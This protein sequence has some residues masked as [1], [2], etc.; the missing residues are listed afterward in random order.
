[1]NRTRRIGLVIAIVMITLLVVACTKGWDGQPEPQ[2]LPATTAA[3]TQGDPIPLP[4]MPTPTPLTLATDAL[5]KLT[6]DEQMAL[7]V[8]PER[9]LRDLAMRLI[10]GVGEIP[11]VVNETT[12]DYEVG[13][14]QL[15]WAHDLERG[16]DF[17]VTAQLI[18]KTDVVYAW[19]EVDQSVDEEKLVATVDRFTTQSYPAERAFFGSEWN[20]GVDNDPRLHILHATGLGSFIA[21]YY[22]SSDEY[23]RVAQPSSNEKEI[24]Y[25]DLNWVNG[26]SQT[27]ST[28]YDNVLAHEFQH[29]IHW[30]TDMNEETWVGEGLSEFAQDVAGFGPTNTFS[31]AFLRVPDTQLTSWG[32][33][34][35]GN[36]PH[37]GAAY[38]FMVYFAQR[39]GAEMTRALV[40]HPAN[41]TDGI[42]DILAWAGSNLTFDDIYADWVVANYVDD[43]NALGSDGLYGYRDFDQEQPQLDATYTDFPTDVQQRT[44][45][46]YGTDYILLKNEGLFTAATDVIFN[47]QGVTTT[48]LADLPSADGP[49]SSWWSNR[50]DTSDTRLTRRFDLSRVTAG[51][52][53]E[54]SATMWWD[55][56]EGYDFAYVIAS[57]DG[58]TWTILEGDS[59]TPSDGLSSFGPGYTGLSEGW[60]SERYDL[61]AFAGEQIYVRFE[62]VTDDAINGR[63]LFI[64]DVTIPAIDYRSNFAQGDGWESEG[65]I[66][67]DNRLRQNWIVQLMTFDGNTLVSVL[68]VKVDDTGHA[69]LP[70]PGLGNGRT[71]VISISGAAPII[72]E[73]ATYEYSIDRP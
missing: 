39:F 58:E 22:S 30:H 70:V 15:F 62:S 66:Y 41:G 48:K 9:D 23:S 56:E 44:V 55:I 59:S 7:V 5:V 64:K 25:I 38:L 27:N 35:S 72:L 37:Y 16:R 40:A 29:M 68:R 34:T 13:D 20:P 54:M 69:S 43:P 26:L 73:T 18:H 4:S 10:P 8:V 28:D 1:M 65:W 12:P 63:G 31:R 14:R 32:T 17:T 47:F 50:G 61:S 51:T 57:R 67:T 21:G 42:N 53:V 19:V 6:T 46:N 71:A 36:D 3:Q 49:S 60:R 45:Y 33:D 52:P 2:A 24:F 11:L